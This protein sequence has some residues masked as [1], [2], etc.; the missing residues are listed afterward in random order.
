VRATAQTYP[1]RRIELWFMDEA[2]VGQKGRTGHRWW[3]RGERPRG[4]CDRR[5]ES[6]HIYG[7]VRPAT[8]DDVALILP[9]VSTEAMPVF[10]DEFAARLAANAHAVPLLDGA[11]WHVSGALVV[12]DRVIPGALIVDRSRVP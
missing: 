7:A 9:T 1:E 11:G 10:L 5:F 6:A 12:P 8:G 4:L 3:R 2:R